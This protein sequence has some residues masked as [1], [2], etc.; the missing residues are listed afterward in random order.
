MTS[1]TETRGVFDEV[2]PQALGMP[3]GFTNGLLVRAG[4]DLLFVSG[5][6]AATNG[7]VADRSFVKQF[8]EALDKT[9]AVVRAAGGAPEHIVRMTVYVTDIEAYRDS[10]PQLNVVWRE[11]MARHYPA[12]TLVA[13]SHLVDLDAA[14]EIE[15]TAALPPHRR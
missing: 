10:R 1:K 6:T 3:R 15:A 12:M 13:V 14:V 9:L 11:R 2:N 7:K 4:Y 5:Q 8:A